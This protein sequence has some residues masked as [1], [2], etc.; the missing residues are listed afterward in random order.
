MRRQRSLGAIASLDDQLH[1]L[2]RH[3]RIC[4]VIVAH[5]DLKHVSTVSALSMRGAREAMVRIGG[6][7]LEDA[8]AS[9]DGRP[10]QRGGA[11]T[12]LASFASSSTLDDVDAAVSLARF[13]IQSSPEPLRAPSGVNGV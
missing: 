13:A 4:P 3:A 2:E 1:E 10:L 11:M 7:V 5:V 8:V 9:A 12:S 6:R